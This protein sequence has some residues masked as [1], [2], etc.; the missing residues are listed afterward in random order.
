[1]KINK[2]I[3]DKRFTC[4]N[5]CLFGADLKESRDEANLHWERVPEGRSCHTEGSIPRGSPVSAGDG[6]KTSIQRFCDGVSSWRSSERYCGA[7]AWRHF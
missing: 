5:K 2:H 4:V 1:M 6:A 3:K 7:R